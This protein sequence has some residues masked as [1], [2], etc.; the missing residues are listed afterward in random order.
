[1]LT[2]QSLYTPARSA[3]LQA[4]LS[5]QFV[6]SKVVVFEEDPTDEP[7]HDSDDE[8]D[9]M[10]SITSQSQAST[11]WIHSEHPTMS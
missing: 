9:H 11:V 7:K 5:V 3:S 10:R 2:Y 1:M 8:R 6:D 4:Q